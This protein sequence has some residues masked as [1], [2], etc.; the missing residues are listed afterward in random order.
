MQECAKKIKRIRI[1]RKTMPIAS[2]Q[3]CGKRCEFEGPH[4]K[5][6]GCMY[7]DDIVK[8]DSP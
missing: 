2:K 1:I 3:F 6:G 7:Q 4:R 5:S 8:D